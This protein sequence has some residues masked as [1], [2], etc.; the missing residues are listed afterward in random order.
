MQF[1]WFEVRLTGWVV[2]LCQS[3]TE[4][5]PV[6]YLTDCPVAEIFIVARGLRTYVRRQLLR[7]VCATLKAGS[8]IEQCELAPP[9]KINPGFVSGRHG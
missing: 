9:M 4:P 8:H 5:D 2:P 3:P 7:P 1:L 6:E